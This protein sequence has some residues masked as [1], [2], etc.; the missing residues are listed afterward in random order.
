MKKYLLIGVLISSFACSGCAALLIGAVGAGGY[1]GIKK[2]TRRHPRLTEMQRRS[3]ECREIEGK[4]EDVLRATVTVFQDRGYSVKTSDY[5]GGIIAAQLEKPVLDITATIEE[6]ASER[7][8]MRITIKDKDGVVEDEKVFAKL[9]EDIQAEV[10]RRIN[11]N[12]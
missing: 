6:F 8:K 5:Q 10:F 1:Y 2:I 11:L 9:F 3:L 4:R 12:K 7:I